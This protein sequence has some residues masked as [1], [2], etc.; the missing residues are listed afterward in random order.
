MCESDISN[1]IFYC[2]HIFHV[3]A[4]AF[5][6]VFVMNIIHSDIILALTNT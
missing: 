4:M 5:D 2:G 6:L 1:E 3:R